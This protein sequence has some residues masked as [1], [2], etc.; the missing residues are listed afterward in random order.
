[1]RALIYVQNCNNN[2]FE[3]KFSLG[4]RSGHALDDDRPPLQPMICRP[5]R[6]LCRHFTA[7]GV[8]C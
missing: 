8:L 7:V 4:R 6:N 2:P 1:M 5:G 3:E